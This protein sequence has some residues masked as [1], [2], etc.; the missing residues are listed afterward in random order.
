MVRDP[1]D[2]ER[3]GAPSLRGRVRGFPRDRFEEA[4]ARGRVP[5]GGVPGDRLGKEDLPHLRT[6]GEER[7]DPLVLVSEPDLEVL[8][9]LSG[10]GKTEVP[11]FDDPGVDG[12]HRHLVDPLSPHEEE[13]VAAPRIGRG[14]IRGPQREE[15]LRPR[16][17]E[18]QGVELGMAF[19][20]QAEE[21]VDLPLEPVRSGA[22]VGERP[23]GARGGLHAGVDEP[24]RGGPPATA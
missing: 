12:P 5:H 10:A 11:R 16:F 23:E 19:R 3:G 21:V 1:L 2:L 9:R 18:A 20:H 13:P 15:F 17:M 22:D 8:D 6:T 7:F 4:D 24:A 14:R